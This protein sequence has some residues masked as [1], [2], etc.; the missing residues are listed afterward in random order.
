M[1]IP[2][3]NL[4]A[5][6]DTFF[7]LFRRAPNGGWER[8]D[9]QDPGP[10]Y[11]SAIGLPGGINGS[12]FAAINVANVH[13]M[14]LKPG[15]GSDADTLGTSSVLIYD[16][17]AFPAYQA[18]CCLQFHDAQTGDPYPASYHELESALESSGRLV[19]TG[20]PPNYVC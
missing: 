20:C 1:N 11:R 14:I 4:T 3:E 16:S 10:A 19:D 12:Y 5:A 17:E 2:E 15:V 7:G 8:P 6:A 9:P 18:E 13:G